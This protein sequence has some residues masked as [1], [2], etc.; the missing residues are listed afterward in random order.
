MGKRKRDYED[1]IRERARELRRAGMAY[2]EIR[3]ALGID[4]PKSTL[5]HWVSDVL[6][7]LEQQQRIV[8]KDREAA[9]RGRQG[10]AW[11]G[12]SGF[13]RE[14][15]RRRLE[16]A[17][18]RAAPIVERLLQDE[19]AQ[20]LMVAALYMGEGSKRGDRFQSRTAILASFKHFWRFCA[21]IWTS[22]KTSFT[23]RYQLLRAWMKRVSK[24]IGPESQAYL[25]ASFTN[26]L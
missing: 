20:L 18:Q 6:L 3:E 2:S 21:A 16:A 1:N 13:N 23:A 7:S 24:Y 19:D 15:K 4:I 14:M 11:G 17:Q 8:E 9:S 26:Q 5:N 25:L 22:T 10:G 12:G